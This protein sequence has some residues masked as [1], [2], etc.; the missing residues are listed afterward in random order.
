MKRNEGTAAGFF[1][2]LSPMKL[3]CV[4]LIPLGGKRAASRSRCWFLLLEEEVK[5]RSADVWS[6]GHSG[7]IAGGKNIGERTLPRQAG[8]NTTFA[9]NLG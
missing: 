9:K 6:S 1:R 4:A 5:P 3:G 7:Q 8:A 2:R